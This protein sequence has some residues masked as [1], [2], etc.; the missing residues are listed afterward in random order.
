MSKTVGNKGKFRLTQ[1]GRIGLAVI[2][3]LAVA[4]SS[5]AG[6]KSSGKARASVSPVK[7]P[8]AQSAA[9]SETIVSLPG[10]KASANAILVKYKDSFDRGADAAAAIWQKSLE[11]DHE[12]TTVPGLKRLVP[13]AGS[14]S[15]A[16]EEATLLATIKELQATGLFEYVE[17]DWQVQLLA[18]PTD[19]AF[20]DGTLWGLQNTGQNGGTANVDVNAVPAWDITSGSPSVIVGVVDTGI[21]YTHQDIAGNMWTNPGEIPGN[22][23]DDDG[24]GY[25][26]DVYGINAIDGSGDPF[27]DNEHGTHVAGTIAATAFDGGQHVGVAYNA[28]LMA[29]KFLSASGS[30]STSDAI[31]CIDYA[32]AQGVDILNNSWGGG[33][34]SE[35]LEESIRAANDAGLLF[36]AAA[37]NSSA[38]NDLTPNYPSNYDIPNIVAVSAVDRHGDLADFS[39]YGATTV[40]IAAPGVDIFSST[41]ASDASYDSFDGTSMA[42]PHIVGV[43][44]L[45]VSQFPGAGITEIKNRMLNTV[46]PLASLAGR[47]STG[48]IV[49]AHAALLVSA[50]GDLELNLSMNGL[51]EEGQSVDFYVTVTD[52]LPVTGATVVANLSGE[53]PQAFFDDGLTPDIAANDGVYSASLDVP[54][55]VATGNL[56]V[57]ASAPGKNPL[58]TDFSFPIVTRPVN[59]DFANRIVLGPG[60]SQ[61]NGT[62]EFSSAEPKEPLNPSVAGGKTVWWEWTAAESAE[63]TISTT[64]SSYDTT[65]A[66]YQGDSL[67]SL[68][69]LGANDDSG[70]LQSAV[71][72]PAIAG[73]SYQVQVDGYAGSS[74]EIE[75]NYPPTGSAAGSPVIVTQPVGS[76]VIVGDPFTVSVIAAGETPLAYQ[77]SHEGTQIPGATNSAFSVAVS[78]ETDEGGYTV[79]ISNAIGSAVSNSAFVSVD[80][81]GLVP[82]NDDLADA[83]ALSGSGGLAEGSNVRA[84]SE[85]SEPDHAGASTPLASIWYEWTAAANGNLDLDTFGSDFDTTLAVYTGP[86]VDSLFELAS[87]D[88]STGLQSHVSLQVAAGTTYRIAVDGYFE[89]EG[90]VL[91]NYIFSP[92]GGSQSNDQFADRFGLIGSTS[93]TGSNIGTTGEPGEPS[94]AGVSVP[95]SSV[96]WSWEAPSEGAVTISTD[97][98]DFD[99]T[100]AAYTG[101]SIATLVEIASNDDFTGLTSQVSFD[102][103]PGVAYAIAVD[104]YGVSEGSIELAVFHGPDDFD[105]DGVPDSSDNCPNVANADQSDIDSDLLGDVCDPDDDNDRVPDARDAFPS[106]PSESV[107]TDNDGIGNNADTDDDNDGIPDE[108]DA[109]PLDPSEYLDSDNDGIG[110]NADTDSGGSGSGLDLYTLILMTALWL[111]TIHRS[112]RKRESRGFPAVS[113]YPLARG[114]TKRV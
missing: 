63:V 76:S 27:D 66:I 5:F 51:A 32:V 82:A 21:R 56:T 40:D 97:N 59:D 28:R 13:A 112:A 50:D 102:A 96:W 2:L 44:A 88:D 20:V 73:V 109:F 70:G 1:P 77:W 25:I 17:P 86:A 22:G 29:L 91:L 67:E 106:D 93:V 24:N 78:A 107:D 30:G 37:G 55:G 114:P 72:F 100:L 69:L 38:D 12:F 94:H 62:N 95:I 9:K 111:L 71:T 45:L 81:V 68:N 33:S 75:L 83:R 7:G 36:V 15:R 42:T 57:Q 108:Q 49:D 90:Q 18:P 6:V 74:G 85:T 47:V 89:S 19:S 110:D 101:D 60:S 39:S 4:T 98:S 10:G 52:L 84:T 113:G 23:A 104:G 35:A 16:F 64:G 14:T 11:V 58:T 3:V 80:L 41:A 61:T 92:S 103:S 48:G 79:E 87:N 54:T 65:L 43:A 53:P 8:G 99:T 31:E 34:F 46:K 26:D 105:G